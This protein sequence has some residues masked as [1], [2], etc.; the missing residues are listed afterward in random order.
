MMEIYSRMVKTFLTDVTLGMVILLKDF[1]LNTGHKLSIHKPFTRGL[2]YAQF[3]S[4]L[5]TNLPK[6]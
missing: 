3:I 2:I 1:P 4:L 6:L 5:F